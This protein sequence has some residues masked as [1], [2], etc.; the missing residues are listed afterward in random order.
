M[1][2]KNAI[3]QERREE[4]VQSVNEFKQEMMNY[5]DSQDKLKLTDQAKQT[6]YEQFFTQ[7]RATMNSQNLDDLNELSRDYILK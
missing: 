1:E 3:M 5:F 6:I 2:A 4:W 7:V